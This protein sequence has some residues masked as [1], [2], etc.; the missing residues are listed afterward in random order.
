TDNSLPEHDTVQVRTRLMADQQPRQPQGFVEAIPLPEPG[1][2]VIWDVRW[3]ATDPTQNHEAYRQGHLPRAVHVS[4][5]SR[6]AGHGCPAIDPT[7]NQECSRQHQ[8]NGAVYP[9]MTSHLAGHDCPAMARQ[10]L[11]DPESFTE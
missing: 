8:L 6:L 10:T 11:P 2:L 3:S 5:A 9:S 7:P 4:M 1:R